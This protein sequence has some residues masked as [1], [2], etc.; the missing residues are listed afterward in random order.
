MA[1]NNMGNSLIKL[2]SAESTKRVCLLHPEKGA[3]LIHEIQVINASLTAI[4][5]DMLLDVI[6]QLIVQDFILSFQK[7]TAVAARGLECVTCLCRAKVLDYCKAMAYIQQKLS[8]SANQ[9][10]V[11][12]ICLP[13]ENY[14]LHNSTSQ[15]KMQPFQQSQLG[16]AWVEMMEEGADHARRFNSSAADSKEESGESIWRK[17]VL[18]QTIPA[19]LWHLAKFGD[20]GVRISAVHALSSFRSDMEGYPHLSEITGLFFSTSEEIDFVRAIENLLKRVVKEEEENLPR[21]KKQSED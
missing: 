4:S 15:H 2:I 18:T 20:K 13:K 16:R 12:F 19:R 9:V 5:K 14:F 1:A 3:E 11:I 17:R 21:A 6:S 10:R 7:N 8:E